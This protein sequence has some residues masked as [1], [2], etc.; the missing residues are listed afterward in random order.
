MNKFIDRIKSHP[1]TIVLVFFA[2]FLATQFY[3]IYF[4]YSEMSGP[5]QNGVSYYTSLANY[6][7]DHGY[8]DKAKV[9]EDAEEYWNNPRARLAVF[10][11]YSFHGASPM[12]VAGKLAALLGLSARNAVALLHY[13]GIALAGLA[14]F[15]IIRPEG[16]FPLNVVVAFV[17]FACYSGNICYR[18]FVDPSPQFFSTVLWMLSVWVF[19]YSKRWY[20]YGLLLVPLLLF[21]HVSG[22]YGILVI[23]AVL[24]LLGAVE[25]VSRVKFGELPEDK[26]GIKNG[27]RLL[28]RVSKSAYSSNRSSF[29]N[30]LVILAVLAGS[31]YCGYKAVFSS[32]K[33]FP[34]FLENHMFSGLCDKNAVA[35]RMN[36]S[37]REARELLLKNV[38]EPEV[39]QA[40]EGNRIVSSST[41]AKG[42][43]FLFNY[44]DFKLYFLGWLL[45]LTLGSIFICARR[46]KY[47]Y[48]ALFFVTFCGCILAA[49]LQDAL[50]YRTFQHLEISLLFIYIF[51]LQECIVF[52]WEHRKSF[53]IKS[54]RYV[55]M[56]TVGSVVMLA[57]GALFIFYLSF[58]QIS[59]DFCSRFYAR[60]AW[61]FTA[62]NSY[63]NLPENKV[64]PV[65]YMGPSIFSRSILSLDGLWNRKFY[66]PEMLAC[67]PAKKSD[68]FLKDFIFL[69]EN[70]KNYKTSSEPH[71]FG[72]YGIGVIS[73]RN[74]VIV[75]NTGAFTPGEYIFSLNDSGISPKEINQLKIYAKI[76]GRKYCVSEKEWDQIPDTVMSPWKLPSV[77]TPHH[78]MAGLCI[79][80]V[81]PNY[82]GIRKTFTYR[83]NLKISGDTEEIMIG[84]DGSNIYFVGKIEISR[85]SNSLFLLD[86]DAD[87]S[88]HINSSASLLR[89]NRIEPLLWAI[90]K[91][92]NRL[93]NTFGVFANKYFV[94]DANFGDL[95][96]FKL[97]QK[98]QDGTEKSM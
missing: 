20:I 88:E 1:N 73:P 29:F 22:L 85:N 50:G 17:L 36:S 56:K 83:T 42:L 59:N 53:W 41:V 61:D 35:G 63:L 76:N 64:C 39:L 55:R 9:H 91:N 89:D 78:F 98:Q 60:R 51:G 65:F 54:E 71:S 34:V 11:F 27:I 95:K 52:L 26:K 46:K 2:I 97:Y 81:K 96:A 3:S 33:N 14:V 92:F 69:A 28:S 67:A 66:V 23:G 21:S 25:T 49:L 68:S 47:K 74:G 43:V 77:V 40:S 31:M 12:Y 10:H 80:K 18:G 86:L 19:L 15:L 82:W 6:F 38:S 58:I 94:L 45:P 57:F 8:F 5:M 7:E 62:I 70:A 84:N 13:F 48:L 30:K 16:K 32:G 90:K 87:S 4:R 24:L 93:T 79:S 44:T 75:L 37:I 72:R